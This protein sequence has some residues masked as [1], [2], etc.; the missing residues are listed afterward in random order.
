MSPGYG[1]PMQRLR[2]AFLILPLALGMSGCGEQPASPKAA[3][4]VKTEAVA[5]ESDLLKLTLTPEAQARL[6][7]ATVRVGAGSAA[8]SRATS[9]EIVVPAGVGGVPTNSVSNLQQL[10][11]QQVTAD[12]EVARSRAQVRLAQIALNRAE[13]LVREEAGSVRA[14]DEAA[15]ALATAQAA[16][17]AAVAQ[18]R[19]L[20][21]AIQSLG[22]QPT[23]WVRVPVFGTDISEIERSRTALIRPLGSEDGGGAPRA[24][25]LVQAPPSA[26]AVAGTVDLYFSLNNRDRAYRVGQRVSVTLPIAGGTREGLSVPT[27]AIV[28][29]IYGGE[30]VYARTAPNTYIRQRI[31]TAQVSGDHAILSRGL[32]DG[33]EIVTAGAAELFGS[34]FG[35]AH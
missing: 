35:V 7:L 1:H 15:A 29:D 8:A 32:A 24:A 6:G 10:G 31:E 16:A 11:I 19:L 12:G 3:A 23:L 26:N 30:W 22:N 4:P 21:P 2:P 28:R 9:G 33:A 27:S 25:R 14:R 34:E 20:G 18:R 17:S 13:A 5:H